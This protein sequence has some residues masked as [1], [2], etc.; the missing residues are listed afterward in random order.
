MLLTFSAVFCSCYGG[1][2]PVP[3]DCAP[4]PSPG[5]TVLTDTHYQ[6]DDDD[7]KLVY[8]TIASMHPA[9]MMLM[10]DSIAGHVV[11]GDEPEDELPRLQDFY[12]FV[13][14]GVEANYYTVAG[15]EDGPYYEEV[16]G[17]R[18]YSFDRYGAHYTVLSVDYDFDNELNWSSGFG[19]FTQEAFLREQLSNNSNKLNFIFI[20]NPI[21][22]CQIVE[23]FPENRNCDP[24]INI[25]ENE[26]AN[27]PII[28][29]QGMVDSFD[30][31]WSGNVLYTTSARIDGENNPFLFVQLTNTQV[32]INQM[33]KDEQGDYTDPEE[34]WVTYDIPDGLLNL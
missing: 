12:E 30:Y 31:Y 33:V 6:S 15:N 11:A 23:S 14:N 27:T 32:I 26:F 18:N 1:I 20:T 34:A 2:D 7:M 19:Q 4:I 17:Q 28:V 22:P 24:I 3:C 25:L 21:R 5:F 29:Q 16:F 9:F 8:Y 13:E 10:G